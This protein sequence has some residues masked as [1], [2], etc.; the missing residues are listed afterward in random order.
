M[1]T[2]AALARPPEYRKTRQFCAV[3]HHQNFWITAYARNRVEN[4]GSSFA[5]RRGPQE[6][7]LFRGVLSSAPQIVRTARR[8]S[9][10]L[11]HPSAMIFSA[12]F[13]SAMFAEI[14]FKPTILVPK[15]CSLHIAHC[16]AAEFRSP[17]VKRSRTDAV[18]SKDLRLWRWPP[19]P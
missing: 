14:L 18:F 10:G 8:R 7:A 16:H 11:K 3:V 4:L 19:P 5:L 1:Q 12:S 15:S 9:A 6:F 13:G 17:F 2:N